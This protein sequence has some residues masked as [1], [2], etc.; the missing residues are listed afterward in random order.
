VLAVT[1]FHVAEIS[2]TRSD[3]LVDENEIIIEKPE[4]AICLRIA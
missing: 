4:N 3:S 2:V 1:I